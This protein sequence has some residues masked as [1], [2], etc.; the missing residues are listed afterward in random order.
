[1]AWQSLGGGVWQEKEQMV[2]TAA[3]IPVAQKGLA[4]QAPA[5]NRTFHC[6]LLLCLGLSSHE[7]SL[8]MN[9]LC[10]GAYLACV[11]HRSS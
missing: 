6:L 8:Q 7:H 9:K 10:Q 4:G 1:M 11:I 2:G 5:S 3:E